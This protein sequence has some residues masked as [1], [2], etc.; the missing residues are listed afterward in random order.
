M[1]KPI[2]TLAATMGLMLTGVLTLAAAEPQPA[3][4]QDVRITLD[5][6]G[7]PLGKL[8]KQIAALARVEDVT[9]DPSLENVLVSVKLDGATPADAFRAVL[10]DAGADFAIWGG[11]GAEL[12]VLA[13]GLKARGP[14]A[15][16]RGGKTAATEKSELEAATL[17]VAKGQEAAE[18]GDISVPQ[19]QDASDT[20]ESHVDPVAAFLGRG[21]MPEAVAAEAAPAVS[22]PAQAVPLT[23]PAP[24]SMGNGKAGTS[25]APSAAPAT[26]PS[27]PFA[28]YLTIMSAATPPKNQ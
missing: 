4:G 12:R 23:M 2:R 25:G 15:A 17:A 28:R 22:S 24:T 18:Q 14:A 7:L 20:S 19:V 27:D 9:I 16:A 8:V 26:L 5:A 11:N 6:R 1:S 13:H 3:V 21:G 10:V